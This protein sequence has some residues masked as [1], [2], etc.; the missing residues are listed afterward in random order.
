MRARK[1]CLRV[2]VMRKIPPHSRSLQRVRRARLTHARSLRRKYSIGSLR[3]LLARDL[4]AE[5]HICGRSWAMEHLAATRQPPIA[6]TSPQTKRIS[7]HRTRPTRPQKACVPTGLR[8][9]SLTLSFMEDGSGASPRGDRDARLLQH[10]LNHPLLRLQGHGT[11]SLCQLCSQRQG[12]CLPADSR[13]PRATAA[14]H[15]APVC[16]PSSEAHEM[17][18]IARS[19]AIC[20]EQ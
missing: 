3:A 4:F 1:P 8:S 15:H 9:P 2:T 11:L 19:P 6:V 18:C 17:T 20:W 14:T 13:A 12:D 10:E 7:P 5:P 16:L